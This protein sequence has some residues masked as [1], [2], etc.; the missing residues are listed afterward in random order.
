[1]ITVRSRLLDAR[2][3]VPTSFDPTIEGLDSVAT[4]RA[5]PFTAIHEAG[6][7]IVRSHVDQDRQPGRH[8]E[9]AEARRHE[10]K[11]RPTGR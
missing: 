3:R 11:R 7:G 4:G 8:L 5:S 1:M 9:V 2:G 10:W 6:C